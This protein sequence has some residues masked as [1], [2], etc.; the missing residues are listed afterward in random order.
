M[1][2][3]VRRYQLRL[4][5]PSKQREVGWAG[6]KDR[7]AACGE[8]L[9]QHLDGRGG[10]GHSSAL[11]ALANDIKLPPKVLLPE[12]ANARIQQLAGAQA[13]ESC[14]GHHEPVSGLAGAIRVGQ[15]FD[16][17]ALVAGRK[18]I[19]GGVDIPYE[20]SSELL[21]SETARWGKFVK[22]ANIRME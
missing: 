22:D 15:G 11:P 3:P 20:K 5:Q 19:I 1:D 17:H 4:I 2:G 8:M 9:Q 13:S 6:L 10:Q 12:I 16:V 18:L 21:R 7:V 14:E